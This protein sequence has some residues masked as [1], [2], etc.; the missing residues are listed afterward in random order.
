MVAEVAMAE[1]VAM[2]DKFA[3]RRGIL[4]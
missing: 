4:Q 3:S 2:A 1:M